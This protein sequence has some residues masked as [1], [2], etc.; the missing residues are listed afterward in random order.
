MTRRHIVTIALAVSACL[1]P[2]DGI[3]GAQAPTSA[4]RKGPWL[5]ETPPGTS[6]KLFAQGF[7]STGMYE[8]DTAWTPDGREL[9]WT[10]MAPVSQRGTIVAARMRDDG[11]WSRPFIPTIF[12]GSS[13][14]E[15]FVTPDGRWLWF[16]STRPL[17]GETE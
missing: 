15:P 17:P 14:I 7:V 5:G 12:R 1:L 3:A 11:T 4:V 10:V 16:A 8:R 9:Y 13:D 6:P 2:L